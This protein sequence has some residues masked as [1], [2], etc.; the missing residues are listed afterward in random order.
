MQ[1]NEAL[2]FI[3]LGYTAAKSGVDFEDLVELVSSNF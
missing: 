3:K 2:K 1:A